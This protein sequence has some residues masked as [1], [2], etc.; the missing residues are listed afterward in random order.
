MTFGSFVFEGVRGVQVDDLGA[1]SITVEAGPRTDA[2]EGSINVTNDHEIDDIVF[3]R[4]A[5]QLRI[6]VPSPFRQRSGAGAARRPR[7]V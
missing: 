2:V 6:S 4:D 7:R 3:R 5:D 1:G